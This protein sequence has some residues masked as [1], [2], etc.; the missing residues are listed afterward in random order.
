MKIVYLGNFGVNF[1][2]ESHL[3]YSWEKLG[4]QVVGL[5]EGRASTDQVLAACQD[6]QIFQWSHTHSWLT[7]GSVSVDEMVERLHRSKVKTLSF[8]LDYFASLDL[9]DKRA[10]RVGKTA[11]WK[12][13]YIFTTDGGHEDFYRERGVNHHWLPPGVVE[14]GCKLGTFRSELACD[15]AFVG[16][17]NYH[18]E[19]EF[20]PKLITALQARYGNRFKLFQGYR[21]DRLNDLYASVKVVVGDHVFAGT[22]KYWSDRLPE[23]AG[24][25]GF[26]VYPKTEGMTIP[27]ATY[28]PQNLD[29]LFKQVDYYLA[30]G[31]EREEIRLKCHEHVKAHDTYTNRLQTILEVMGLA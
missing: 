29:D 26:I 15:V 14:Y 30:H 22:P 11:D 3:K 6:A 18:P 24:R 31:D 25:G 17:Q 19:Y 5:Q 23:T 20:R 4:H 8:H 28:E 27:V 16:S 9:W 10:S 13:N 2:T 21:E 12:L 7:N 1:S